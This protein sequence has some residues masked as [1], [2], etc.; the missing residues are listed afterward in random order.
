MRYAVVIQ[1][2]FTGYIWVY[3]L[4][5]KTQEEFVQA[6]KTFS[7]MVKTQYDLHIC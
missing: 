6:F 7:R 5:G 3:P 4:A 1:D 2:E